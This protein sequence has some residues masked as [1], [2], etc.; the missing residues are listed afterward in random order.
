MS[1]RAGST[2][3]FQ[4]DLIWIRKRMDLKELVFWETTLVHQQP[5]V[6]FR[7]AQQAAIEALQDTRAQEF[8]GM[9]D[10]RQARLERIHPLDFARERTQ[11]SEIARSVDIPEGSIEEPEAPHAVIQVNTGKATSP[12]ICGRQNF[13]I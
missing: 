10:L 9:I 8:V 5:F 11:H 1:E 3:I 13:S 6:K 12:S 2:Q 7:Q 4:D